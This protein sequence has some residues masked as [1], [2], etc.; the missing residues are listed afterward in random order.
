MLHEQSAGWAVRHMSS[1]SVLQGAVAAAVVR[2][3]AVAAALLAAVWAA[4]QDLV[5]PLPCLQLQALAAQDAHELLLLLVRLRSAESCAEHQLGD[6]R[7]T[8]ACE[9]HTA[10]AAAAECPGAAA[11][12]V[13]AVAAAAH[14]STALVA[15]GAGR[16]SQT[17]AHLQPLL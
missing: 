3:C 17:V 13:A 6:L 15:A 2:M 10:A 1:P 5:Q 16:T 4:A 9:F 14:C 12:A 11:A 7:G 8:A